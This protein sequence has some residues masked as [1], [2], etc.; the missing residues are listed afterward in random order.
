M[1]TNKTTENEAGVD[2]F[3]HN[4]KDENKRKDSFALKDM[5]TEQTGFNAKM[6]GTSIVGF[7]RYHY[8]YESGREGDA[9]LVGFAPRASTIA[10]Y[11]S[12]SFNKREELLARLGKHKT[13]KGCINI[14]K[15][16]DVDVKTLQQIF[17]N[18]LQHMKELYG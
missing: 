15:L 5:L 18:H 10:I 9:P 11:V 16:A 17:I 1:A 7:G 8:K 6:W 12:G 4:I 14:K 13:D 2:E 3:L